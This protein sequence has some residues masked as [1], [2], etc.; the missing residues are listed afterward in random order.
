MPTLDAP[1]LG[2]VRESTAEQYVPDVFYKVGVV[3]VYVCVICASHGY[4]N[5]CPT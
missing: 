5:S 2:Y 1:E 3:D 4:G